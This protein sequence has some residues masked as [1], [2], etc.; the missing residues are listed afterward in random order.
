MH[1]RCICQGTRWERE[2]TSV[3]LYSRNTRHYRETD[4]VLG[5]MRCTSPT[6][7][8]KQLAKTQKRRNPQLPLAWGRR[9]GGLP[10]TPHTHSSH[11]ESVWTFHQASLS[12]SSLEISPCC[13]SALV[14]SKRGPLL[15]SR[16]PWG[17]AH[18]CLPITAL[19]RPLRTARR[20]TEYNKSIKF[21]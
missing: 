4:A 1:S 11:Q 17:Y 5:G 18:P 19:H 9:R 16:L 15:R 7:N 6:H 2:W 14:H 8:S 10:W 21:L 12:A 3:T 13:F 20:P